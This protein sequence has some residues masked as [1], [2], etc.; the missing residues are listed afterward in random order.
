MSTAADAHKEELSKEKAKSRRKTK[1]RRRNARKKKHSGETLTAPAPPAPVAS[2]QVVETSGVAV[3]QTGF[4]MLEEYSGGD[5]QVV[6]GQLVLPKH[7]RATTSALTT[8]TA[9][10]AATLVSSA[11][12]AS[13]QEV[14][15]VS[16]SVSNGSSDE[17]KG[18]DE[19]VREHSA[20]AADAKE[21]FE[22]AENWQQYGLHP[23]I[24]RGIARLGFKE[25]TEIQRLCLPRAIRDGRDV[26]GAAETGSGKTLA[27]GLPLLNS[28]IYDSRP[29]TDKLQA[30][31]LTPTR[32][33]AFQVDAH[34]TALLGKERKGMVATVVG[35]MSQQKQVRILG[36]KPA[37]LVVTPGRFWALVQ[38]GV[39]HLSDLQNSLRF[40]VVD[41]ADRM[42]DKGHFPELKPLITLLKSKGNN[43]KKRQTFLFSATLL[44]SHNKDYRRKKKRKREEGVSPFL[45]LIQQIGVRGTPAVCSVTKEGCSGEGVHIEES[46]DSKMRLP[47]GL[48]LA[49]VE[50]TEKS[51]C[52]YT[53]YFLQNYQGRTLIFVNTIST[54][55][56]VSK[57]FQLLQIQNLSCLHAN[58][59][60]KQR[61]KALERFRN[62]KNAVLVATDVAA[63]G[64]DIPDV[65]FVMHYGVSRLAM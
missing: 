22:G 62:N 23:E 56:R 5:Y 1:R 28:L 2:W 41:E 7:A 34:L 9:E 13:A 44:Q 43:T 52:N 65:D 24:L 29:E 8:K 12:S 11:S 45:R 33:L 31:V 46:N 50:C 10:E 55:R 64:L 57:V 17:E 4:L 42:L 25:P 61:L 16:V 20:P 35:G 63:R 14:V 47:A 27:Y 21:V 48:T 6:D 60:Q 15:S 36:R 26:L 49:K 3:E 40:L 30:L 19:I 39:E 53:Y 59:Q 37:V 18:E 51:K 58:M 32:E 38:Q 54:L